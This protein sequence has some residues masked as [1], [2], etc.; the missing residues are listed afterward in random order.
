MK[1]IKIY[2]IIVLAIIGLFGCSG[3]NESIEPYLSQGEIIYISKSDS[4][5]VYPGRER[6]MVQ[7]Y[8]SDPRATEM[9]IYWS[10]RADSL[11]IPISEEDKGK[12][13]DV[14]VG[15]AT[16]PI[17]EGNYTVELITHDALGHTSI[18]DEK[19]VNVYGEVFEN[20]V[21]SKFIKSAKFRKATAYVSEGI[22]IVWGSA[23]SEK[24]IGVSIYYTGADGMP[25]EVFYTT[26]E[27]KGGTSLENIDVREPIDY[28]THYLPE[29]LA[30]D[31]FSTEHVDLIFTGS[32]Y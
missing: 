8:M 29:P 17:A 14:Y 21:V 30:I 15:T 19:V 12:A 6:F 2:G 18:V 20:R 5:F 11:I 22:D 27:L 10:Q 31:T 13:I 28:V 16:S 24:E 26:A 1:S 23:S 7:F 3:M 32:P 4:A 25:K 9:H